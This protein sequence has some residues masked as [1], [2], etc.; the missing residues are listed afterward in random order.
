MRFNRG[1]EPKTRQ[2]STRYTES[3]YQGLMRS[4]ADVSEMVDLYLLLENDE[5]FILLKN[6]QSKLS[7]IRDL[8]AEL[9]EVDIKRANI[10]D[11]IANLKLDVKEINGQLRD[12]GMDLRTYKTKKDLDN[13]IQKTIDYYQHNYNPYN[14]KSDV[15]SMEA[16]LL[17]ESKKVQ[18]YIKNMATRGGMIDDIEGFKELVIQKYKEDFQ[19]VLL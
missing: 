11:T 4:E 10:L 8:E 6:K 12:K 14:K 18:S 19:E 15:Y 1:K 2:K 13:S 16:F 7:M 9:V 3:T 17:S 5:N